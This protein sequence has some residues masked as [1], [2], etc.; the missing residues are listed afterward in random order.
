[1]RLGRFLVEV[2][3]GK[4]PSNDIVEIIVNDNAS[5]KELATRKKVS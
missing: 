3:M 1:M 2:S 5:W 4:V